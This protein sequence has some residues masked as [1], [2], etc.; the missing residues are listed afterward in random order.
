MTLP[1]LVNRLKAQLAAGEPSFGVI[2]TVPSVA[3]V[4]TP[5][6]SVSIG[7]SSTWSSRLLDRRSCTG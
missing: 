4:Q 1:A 3:V 6:P 5:P 7:S 2:V